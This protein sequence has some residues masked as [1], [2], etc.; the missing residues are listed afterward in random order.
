MDRNY[1]IRENFCEYLLDKIKTNMT[2]SAEEEVYC[3]FNKPSDVYNIGSLAPI[4]KTIEGDSEEGDF[5]TEFLA[6]YA[7]YSMGIEFKADANQSSKIH[8]NLSFNVYYRIIPE[9]EW[10]IELKETKRFVTAYKR[11]KIENVAVDVDLN[12]LIKQGKITLTE[13]HMN[14]LKASLKNI[15]SEIENDENVIRENMDLL[16]N[17]AMHSE[18]SYKNF[19]NQIVVDKIKV[20]PKWNIEFQL[21]IRNGTNGENYIQVM[22]VNMTDNQ[23]ISSKAWDGYL[24]NVRFSAELINGNIIPFEFNLLEDSFRYKRDMWGIGINCVAQ[25]VK[26]NILITENTPVF[27]QFRYGKRENMPG[28][29]KIKVQETSFKELAENPVPV[30]DNL[31]DQMKEYKQYCLGHSEEFIDSHSRDRKSD[32]EQF[33]LNLKEFEDEINRFEKGIDLLRN[34][35]SETSKYHIIYMAFK[36]MNETFFELGKK[37]G[38]D[39]WRQFQVVFIVSNL[40][41]IVA[42]YWVDDFKDCNTI[43]KIS[44]LWF[45]TGGGKTEAYLG[46][47]IFNLF[48]DRLRGKDKGVTALFRFPLRILSLQQFQRIFYAIMAANKIKLKYNIA[49]SPFSIGHWVGGDQTPNNIDKVDPEWKFYIDI[50]KKKNGSKEDNQ[51]VQEKLRRIKVCPV[52]G[53]LVNVVWSNRFGTIMHMC[54]NK[55]CNWGK[56]G[57]PLPIYITDTDI[58]RYLPAVIV[59]TVDKIATSGMQ[60]KFANIIG[61]VR[62]YSKK[63]GYSW[64]KDSEEQDWQEIDDYKRKLLRPTLQVQDELHLLKEDLGAYDSHYETMVQEM[65]KQISGNYSWKIIT[66]TATIQDYNRHISHLYGKKEKDDMSVRFPVEGPKNDESFYST[67]DSDNSIGRYFVGIMGHNKTHINTIIDVIYYFHKE[68]KELKLAT[69]DGFMKRTGIYGINDTEKKEI[70]DDYEI[71]LNYVLTKRN[72]DQIAESINSQIGDY[73]QETKLTHINNEMLTGG[74]TPDQLSTVL[75]KVEKDYKNLMDK[76]RVTSIT[77]TSMISHGVDVDRFNFMTFFGMPRQTSEYIQASSRVGRRIPGITIVVFAP[78]KE[79][80]QSFFRYFIKYHEYLDRLVEVPAINRWSKF[81][82]NKTFPGVLLGHILNKYNREFG[83]DCFFTENLRQCLLGKSKSE[84]DRNKIEL[85]EAMKSYYKSQLDEG[86]W[87]NDVIEN[88]IDRLFESLP[89]FQSSITME[90]FEHIF[91]EAPM[92]SLRDTEEDVKFYKFNNKYKIEF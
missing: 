11:M 12:E 7:P 38:Y 71:D 60:S 80:D 66:S 20:I 9:Y 73:L 28:P 18:S 64:K 79:R 47:V 15:Y 81:S 13:D 58:Y 90:H 43:E 27:K 62:Y 45:P 49:G 32:L 31:R 56:G 50:L 3:K 77:A 67:K 39:S 24:F 19:C 57:L 44:V 76:D 61:G 78:Q 41:D 16:G 69:L 85:K 63:K 53:S 8:L 42:Q 75:D 68:I 46:I 84:R 37:R 82:I 55:E 10:Q 89:R 74:T 35:K 25:K 72:A 51:K 34:A 65:E 23:S 26:D 14:T 48:F 54:Q 1:K 30:L 83:K 92:M 29:S 21:E 4:P 86:E 2:G 87:F 70:L 91:G 88:N 36:Y 22:L 6:R 59:S 17:E 33:K 40:I 52:C 5:Q